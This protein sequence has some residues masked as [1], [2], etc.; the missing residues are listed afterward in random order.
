VK[1]E[2]NHEK[3]ARKEKEEN[4]RKEREQYGKRNAMLGEQGLESFAVFLS[5]LTNR[6]GD[7][8]TGGEFIET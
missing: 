6:F 7:P 3:A 1:R 5:V 8:I 2:H 4:K